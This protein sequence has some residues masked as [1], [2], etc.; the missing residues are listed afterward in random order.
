[1]FI[2]SEINENATAPQVPLQAV[3]LKI[4]SSHN[5]RE[6]LIK[7]Q[8]WT[9]WASFP[10]ICRPIS[11]NN[12]SRWLAVEVVLS[13]LSHKP[14]LHLQSLL[15]LQRWESLFIYKM[16]TSSGHLICYDRI[17]FCDRLQCD[18]ISTTSIST[19]SPLNPQLTLFTLATPR[20][21]RF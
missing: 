8:I 20:Y 6:R 15:A 13:C 4:K 3:S 14:L 19:T 5:I 11:L 18:S 9:W 12:L 21:F 17:F 10:N 2:L 1:M 16:R 7:S